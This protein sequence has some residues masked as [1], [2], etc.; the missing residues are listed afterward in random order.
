[1]AFRSRNTDARSKLSALQ[2]QS[3]DIDFAH[4]KSTLKNQSIV[5]EIESAVKS[6]K[7]VSYDVNAQISAISK[8]ESLAIANANATLDRV[9]DELTALDKTIKNIQDTRSFEQLTVSDV[10]R[11]RP[12]I[13]TI[14]E[15]M[16]AKG[17]WTVP[18][19]KEK[20]GE[21]VIM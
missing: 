3:I 5:T 1:M 14:T 2:S 7:P 19:Y 21:L 6:F 13:E 12:D 17:N 4:Y 16:V 20:F 10:V 15:K 18:G 9:K 8:F 11:A